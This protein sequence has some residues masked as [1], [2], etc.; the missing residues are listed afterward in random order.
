MVHKNTEL[1]KCLVPITLQNITI[2]INFIKI[3]TIRKIQILIHFDCLTI[4]GKPFAPADFVA[5]RLQI[6]RAL[7]FL[8]LC[9]NY[10]TV[11]T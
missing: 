11:L 8:G 7:R 5:L 9:Y 2:I 10:V 3:Y 4:N 6:I 1:Y